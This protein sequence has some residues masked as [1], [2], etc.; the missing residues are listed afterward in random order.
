MIVQHRISLTSFRREI[1]HYFRQGNIG[2]H[3]DHSAY[4]SQS[5]VISVCYGK[6]VVRYVH[7]LSESNGVL[8]L[9]SSGSLLSG[10]PTRSARK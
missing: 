10:S 5:A 2:V 3:V 9:L 1:M 8:D 7:N 4:I 6:D